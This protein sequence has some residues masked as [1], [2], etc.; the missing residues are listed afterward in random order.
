[1]RRFPLGA[2]LMVA[3]AAAIAIAIALTAGGAGAAGSVSLN[4]DVFPSTILTSGAGAIRA[5]FANSGPSTANHVV[6]TVHLN[7]ATFDAADSSTGCSASVDVVTCLLV[8]GGS[9][10]AN[11]TV[12]TTIAFTNGPTTGDSTTFASSVTWNSKTAGKPGGTPGNQTFTLAGGGGTA[13]L[14]ATGSLAGSFSTCGLGGG[15]ADATGNSHEIKVTAGSNTANLTCTPITV[16][17]DDNDVLFTKMP[18]LTTPATVALT[19]PDEQLPWPSYMNPPA[20]SPSGQCE[21]NGKRDPCAPTQL[22]EYPNYPVLDTSVQVPKCATG[23]AL[24]A[25]PGPGFSTD[26]CIVSIQSTDTDG[27]FDAGTITLLAQGSNTGDS[28]F[29]GG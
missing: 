10:A 8:S 22:L 1:M 7:G 20:S 27:D 26:A 6:V 19:F 15:S 2:R 25:H 16:G 29:H 4:L 23:P 12:F 21:K 11:T 3:A 13:Q 5:A 18:S 14:L 17:I 24:P 28:G 9:V